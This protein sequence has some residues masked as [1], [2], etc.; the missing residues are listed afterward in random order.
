MHI[1][2]ASNNMVFT[3]LS[4]ND[5]IFQEVADRWFTCDGGSDEI[6]FFRGVEFNADVLIDQGKAIRSHDTQECGF[7]VTNSGEAVGAHGT[8]Q[9]PVQD[10]L[11]PSMSVLD[12]AFGSA[13][14]SIGIYNT[15]SATPVLAIKTRSGGGGE[16]ILLAVPDAGGNVVGDHIN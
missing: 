9:I 11:T 14:G 2:N 16:W 1:K 6:I 5:I 15:S 13:Q 3:A 10:S 7:F 12:T 4:G 8:I